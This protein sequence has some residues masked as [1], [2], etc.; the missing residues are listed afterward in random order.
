MPAWVGGSNRGGDG[1]ADRRAVRSQLQGSV[2]HSAKGGA[3]DGEGGSILLTTSFLNAIGAPGL[4]I[5]SATKAAV[6]SLGRSLG[7]EFASRGIRVNAV[8]PGPI[9]TPFHRKLGLSDQD[10]KTSAARI[11]AR[12]PLQR[13]GEA[14]EVARAPLFLAGSDSS[15]VTGTELLVDSGISQI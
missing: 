13:F 2:L 15:F 9:S 5:L 14:D 6:R 4:S 10:L 8:C 1:S 3:A 12:V 7:A 11:E